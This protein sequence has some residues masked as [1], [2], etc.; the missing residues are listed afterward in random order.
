VL[1]LKGNHGSL[2]EDVEVFVA[3]QKD[4]GFQ[5]TTIIQAGTVDGDHGHIET[6]KTTVVHDVKCLQEWRK[7]PGLNTY[8]IVARS[9]PGT[10]SSSAASSQHNPFTRF[11]WPHPS[12][13][14]NYPG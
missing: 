10:T 8:A 2:R 9:P 11:P 4:A 1:T 6:R 13:L 3:E 5:E 7:W 12:T 14:V